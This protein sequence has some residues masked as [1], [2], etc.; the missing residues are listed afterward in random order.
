MTLA[1][2]CS[3]ILK[4]HLEADDLAQRRLQL[5]GDALGH[6]R[7]RDPPR[8]R[9]ADQ[10]AGVGLAAPELQRDLRQLRGLAGAGLAAHDDHLVRLQCLRDL[11][12]AV[13]RRAAI[14][15]T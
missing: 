14:L 7:S 8:L 2:G 1:P 12:R 10:L 9:V 4:P 5:F 6:A 3:P 13:R 15:D 11:V